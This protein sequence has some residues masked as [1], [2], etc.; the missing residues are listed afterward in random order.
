MLWTLP[1]LYFVATYRGSLE[2][3]REIE[4]CCTGRAERALLADP[5]PLVLARCTRLQSSESTWPL[6]ISEAT[7]ARWCFSMCSGRSRRRSGSGYWVCPAR[8]VETIVKFATQ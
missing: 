5:L 7:L 8:S 3:T 6:V 2:K 1:A 4:I